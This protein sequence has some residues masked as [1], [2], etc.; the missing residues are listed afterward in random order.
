MAQYIDKSALVAEI[1]GYI[2]NYKE[3][4]AKIN[5]N[6]STWVDSVSMIESKIGV[7]QHLLS[8]LDTLEVK[9][10]EE[11]PVSEDLEEA[12]YQ[13]G[14]CFESHFGLASM[15]FIKGAEW[16]KENLWKPVDGDDLPEVDREVIA[17]VEENEHYKVVF[18]HRPPE[19]WD[20]KNILTGE[21]TRYE[22]K[23]YD[24]GGWNQPTVKWWLDIELPKIEGG[25]V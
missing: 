8:F 5:R 25:D 14:N 1:K 6:D 17:L 22:P 24:K 3:I 10:V 16:Q 2:S 20:G 12:A 19:Y 23:R 21:V 18:A 9:E 7:L 11:E 4:V 13:F 15:S